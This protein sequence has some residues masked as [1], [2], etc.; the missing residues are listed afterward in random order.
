MVMIDIYNL[1]H[2]HRQTLNLQEEQ[3]LAS[4]HT[5][6]RTHTLA[7]AHTHTDEDSEK[8]NKT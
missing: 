6:A 2:W 5:H 4:K 3:L 8:H 1:R 7:H